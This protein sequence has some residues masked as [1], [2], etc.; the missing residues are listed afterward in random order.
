[1]GPLCG[2]SIWECPQERPQLR[3]LL[4]CPPRWRSGRACSPALESRRRSGDLQKRPGHTHIEYQSEDLFVLSNET[5]V[6]TVL[7]LAAVALRALLWSA[8]PLWATAA[9]AAWTGLAWRRHLLPWRCTHRSCCQSLCYDT[10]HPVPTQK[11]N[12]LQCSV[13]IPHPPPPPPPPMHPVTPQ[14]QTYMMK[15]DFSIRKYSWRSCLI[16]LS[17]FSLN[18]QILKSFFTVQSDT[19]KLDYNLTNLL[20]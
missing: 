14:S 12:T 6:W 16:S 10:A 20:E 1:M 15:Q 11:Q 5:C 18:L 8:A 13:I 4:R 2:G 19:L 7:T 9:G 3:L 17:L